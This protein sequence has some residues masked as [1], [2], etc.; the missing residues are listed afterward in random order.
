MDLVDYVCCAVLAGACG[1]L[2]G[3]ATVRRLLGPPSLWRGRTM[4]SW[5]GHGHGFPPPLRRRRRRG[6]GR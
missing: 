2:A 1:A 3:W 4:R 6:G 5:P